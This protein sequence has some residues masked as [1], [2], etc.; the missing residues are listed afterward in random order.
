MATMIESLLNLASPALVS[1]LSE[2]TSESAS[3]VS[4]GLGAAIPA[5]ASTIANRAGDQGFVKNLADLATRTAAGPDP[6]ESTR[7]LASSITGADTTNPVGG[8]LSSLFGRNLSGVTGSIA[9]YAGV[10]GSTA[11]KLVSVAAPLVLGY[12]GRRM[13]SDNLTADGLAHML[14]GQ[15]AELAASMPSG[16]T[17]PVAPEPDERA[18]IAVE[19]MAPVIA[20]NRASSGWSVPGIALLAA[21]GIAGLLWW[22]RDKPREVARVDTH[23]EMTG[24]V[25]TSGVIET[26]G[27]HGGRFTRTLPGNMNITI[28]SIGSAEDRLST[29]LA[30]PSAGTTTID[31]DRIAFESASAKLTAGSGEQ[32]KNIAAILRAY[33]RASV[34][35]AGYA[36]SAG[37]GAANMALS[38]A[39][40][41]AVAARLTAGGV[42]SDR[43]RAMG[44]GSEKPVADNSTEEGRAQ[45][46]RVELEIS[47]R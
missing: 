34:T 6:V 39:R 27:P 23:Q 40:A 1:A 45:N 46:R 10:S 14:Q 4:R 47:V 32:L 41:D 16:F 9:R 22:N 33:P 37:S 28:P 31:V 26:T 30:S 2:G 8:F 3:A 38:R 7:A 11:T 24:V 43:V 42:P 21:L 19:T 12:L 5:L 17:M 36:D 20:E 15:R 18:P 13:R 25:G 44:Y 29:Y 35:V